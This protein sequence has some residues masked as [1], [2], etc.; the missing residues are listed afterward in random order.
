METDTEYQIGRP[1][2]RE[3]I[4][5]DVVRKVVGEEIFNDPKRFCPF[6]LLSKTKNYIA[7]CTSA[8][9]PGHEH[10]NKGAHDLRTYPK[11]T[12][13]K[14]LG[15]LTMVA[16]T[17]ESAFVGPRSDGGGARQVGVP[18][19]A[20][21][22]FDSVGGVIFVPV[23]Y[24]TPHQ[25]EI[26]LPVGGSSS[27]FGETGIK[28]DRGVR[29][30]ALATAWN[31]SETLWAGA[32]GMVPFGLFED[33]GGA[34][35]QVTGV[36]AAPPVTFDASDLSPMMAGEAPKSCAKPPASARGCIDLFAGAGGL[37]IGVG[38]AGF[39]HFA[40]IEHDA[41]TVAT[42]VRNGLTKAV[43]ADVG[44]FDFSPWRGSV[45][46]LT[47]GPPCQPFSGGG[48]LRGAADERNGW[49]AA[50]AQGARASGGADAYR[51]RHV[52]QLGGAWRAG[53][54]HGLDHGY[55]VLRASAGSRSL[56]PAGRRRTA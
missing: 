42:L 34:G 7:C 12:R 6:S 23:R 51:H 53:C 3:C 17:T 39:N 32:D 18:R 25:P 37:A 31:W 50:L 16:A 15:L 35:G 40:L 29:E 21:T 55:G 22:V 10:V 45:A 41:R 20:S 1:G 28:T 47:G 56:R 5:K 43:C 46:L 24:A 49:E 11:G 26:G 13:S 9:S 2:F 36:I 8:N 19:L 33:V 54:T 44:T 38:A 30:A 14:L 27:W 52:A 48:L 4:S